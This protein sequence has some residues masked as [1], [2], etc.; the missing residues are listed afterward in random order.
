[1]VTLTP[2]L[3][4]YLEAIYIT[5]LEKKVVRVKDI[6]D[7]RNVKTPSV[8]SAMKAL[9]EKDLIIQES[10]GYIELTDEGKK[11]GENI[12]EKHKTLIKFLHNMLG[13]D[14]STASEDACEI[15]HHINKKTYER[16]IKFIEFIETCPEGE[17]EWLL[18]FYHYAESGERPDKCPKGAK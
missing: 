14:I 15:E 13:I 8:V 1:M 17:P 3:E 10:Y 12:Y 11:I 9:S 5:S 4:D 7:L 18:N 2:S 16:I 6:A